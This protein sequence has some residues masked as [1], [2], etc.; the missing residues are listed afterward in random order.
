MVHRLQV[1]PTR[2]MSLAEIEKLFHYTNLQ[3]K[4]EDEID[5]EHRLEFL[6]FTQC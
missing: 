3:P 6:E 1:K 5:H 4:W 2:D